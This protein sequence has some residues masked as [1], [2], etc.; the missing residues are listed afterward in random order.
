MDY[1]FDLGESA[2]A[3]LSAWSPMQLLL[4][5]ALTVVV[6]YLGIVARVAAR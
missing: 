4:L 6:G 5:A 3:A 1:F 2:V